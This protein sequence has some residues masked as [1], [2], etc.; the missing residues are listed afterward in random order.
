TG[1]ELDAYLGRYGWGHLSEILPQKSRRESASQVDEYFEENMEYLPNS[2][3]DFATCEPPV[4]IGGQRPF[5]VG[6]RHCGTFPGMA[7]SNDDVFLKPAPVPMPQVKPPLSGSWEDSTA[8]MKSDHEQ[9]E[10]VSDTSLFP[11]CLYST[12]SVERVSVKLSN[13]QAITVNKFPSSNKIS[14]PMSTTSPVL[15][16]HTK[17]MAS[18]YNLQTYRFSTGSYYGLSRIYTPPNSEPGSY[19]HGRMTA[20]PPYPVTSQT[21]FSLPPPLTSS[22]QSDEVMNRRNNP[23]VEKR[24]IHH[25]NHPGCNKVYTKSSHLK[26]HQRIHT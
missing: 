21:T 25:C 10:L 4:Q 23:E 5:S 3:F 18:E 19:L 1:T 20:P 16:P 8:S 6:S 26:A 12:S 9:A 13:T 22:I 24:R 14:L 7:E 11:P 17:N 15:S 2:H